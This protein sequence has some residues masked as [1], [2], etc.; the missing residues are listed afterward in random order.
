MDAKTEMTDL[1]VGTAAG[2]PMGNLL[3]RYWVPALLTFTRARVQV[4]SPDHPLTEREPNL[5][6][7]SP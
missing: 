7:S 6:S 3:R 5:R 4:L 2:A 1:L